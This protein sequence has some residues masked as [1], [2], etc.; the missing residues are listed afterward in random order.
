MSMVRQDDTKIT[1]PRTGPDLFWKL[2]CDH[3]AGND[4]RKWKY[5]AILALRENA[6]W[7]L[8]RIGTV[9]GH[10][11]GH[12]SRCLR[13]IKE[14]LREQFQMS[15]DYLDHSEFF[16][17]DEL[18]SERESVDR[19]SVG[20]DSSGGDSVDRNSSGRNSSW[21][22]DCSSENGAVVSERSRDSVCGSASCDSE[23]R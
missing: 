5:L 7:P 22:T 17:G 6:G 23:W 2:V 21:E 19:G 3:F 10:P 11:K 1:L 8:E 9:F 14:E 15:P 20:R 16:E 4:S 12:I 13:R 18:L